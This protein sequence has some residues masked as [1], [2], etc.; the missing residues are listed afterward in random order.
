M[1][2]LFYCFGDMHKVIRPYVFLLALLAFTAVVKGSTSITYTMSYGGANRDFI[3]V[4]PNSYTAGSSLPMVFNLH[5]YGSDASQ[6]IFYSQMYKTV[7]SNGFIAVFPNGIGNAW[8]SGWSV[9]PVPDDVGFISAIIDT[10]TWLYNIN[11]NRVYACGMSNGGFMSYKLACELSNR[12]AAVASVTGTI[13][14]LTALNCPAGVAVPVLQIHGTDDPLVPY[15]GITGAYG[16]EE[17][18]D[19]WK[20]RNGCTVAA[21]TTAVPDNNVNDSST[22]QKIVYANCSSPHEVWLYKINGGGHTWPNAPINYIYGPTNRD[23]DA[24]QEIWDFFNRFSLSNPTAVRPL[25]ESGLEVFPNPFNDYVQ[26]NWPQ[27]AVSLTATLTDVSGK[28]CMVIGT[29][30]SPGIILDTR[31]LSPGYYMVQVTDGHT[32]RQKALIKT[33]K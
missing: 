25:Q 6:Q 2:R 24:S 17:T 31:T 28:V 19:F 15:N 1:C 23:I 14:S 4:L 32:Q 7:D 9:T 12:L 21:D 33:T 22:V 5:G 30:S 20:A 13:N 27:V 18:I 16:V 26:V 11:L 29:S 10:M 8:N 3:V